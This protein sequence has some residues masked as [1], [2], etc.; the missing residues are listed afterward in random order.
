MPHLIKPRALRPGATV[1]IV[2][3]AGPIDGERLGAGVAM[4]EA[5]G[6]RIVHREDVCAREGYLAGSD[7]RRAAEFMEMVEAPGVDGILCARGGYGSLRILQRLDPARVRE[8]AKPV[9]GYS[10]ATTLHLWLRRVAGLVSFH[11]PMLERGGDL[12]P[13]EL[14]ALVSALTGRERSTRLAGEPGSGGVA[15][16]RLVAT[17]SLDE[18]RVADHPFIR[19]YFASE[20]ARLPS[21]ITVVI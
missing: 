12:E 16:G 1:G 5:A 11:G 17:G 2:A 7:E 15:E 6:F 8:A 21:P 9:V 14:H 18:V 10:D 20:R 13:V 3:P 4:L 19:E